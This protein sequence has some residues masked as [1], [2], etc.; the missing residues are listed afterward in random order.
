MSDEIK[1]SSCGEL[2]SRQEVTENEGDCPACG[3]E[4]IEGLREVA[5]CGCGNKY[6]L[7][8]HDGDGR[9]YC[10]GQFCCP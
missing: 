3:A 5:C 1:C 10:G 4:L 7:P 6:G 8:N 2:V 9:F